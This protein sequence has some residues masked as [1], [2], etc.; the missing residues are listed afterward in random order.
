MHL[1]PKKYPSEQRDRATRMVL[2]RLKEYPSVWAAAQGLGPKLGVGPETL[3]KSVVQAQVDQGQRPG[4]SSEELAEIKR[5]R[6]ENR[7]L[8]EANEI[9][10]AASIFFPRELDP[11]RR[12]PVRLRRLPPGASGSGSLAW[13]GAGLS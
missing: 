1:M 10:K 9:L 3:R 6:A 5:L 4:S 7:D 11:R 13:V 8:K 12:P 2:D